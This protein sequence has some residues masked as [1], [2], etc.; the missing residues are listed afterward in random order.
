M[1]HAGDARAGAGGGVST[2]AAGTGPAGTPPP[3]QAAATAAAAK[4]AQTV[5]APTLTK[6]QTVG[7]A[8]Q[9]TKHVGAEGSEYVLNLLRNV[10]PPTLALEQVGREFGCVFLCVS[11]MCVWCVL[12]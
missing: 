12:C 2:T 7:A 6:L 5:V 1:S 10:K 11:V 3:P 4:K 9:A 8:N